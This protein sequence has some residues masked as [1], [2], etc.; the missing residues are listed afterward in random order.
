MTPLLEEPLSGVQ[1]ARVGTSLAVWM[2][3]P[4]AIGAYRIVR[5]DPR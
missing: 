2:L 4:L 3:L 5:S 1:W